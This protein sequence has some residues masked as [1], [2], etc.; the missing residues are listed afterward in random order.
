M[1]SLKNLLVTTDFHPAS[2]AAV[3]MAVHLSRQFESRLTLL[4]VQQ[5]DTDGIIWYHR[6]QLGAMLLSNLANK[7]A[8]Q[9]VLVGAATVELGS[10]VDVILRKATELDV[11]LIVLGIGEA[12]SFDQVSVGPTA[13]SVIEHATQPVLAI[14]PGQSPPSI[15]RILCPVDNSDVSRRGLKNAIRWA[16]ACGSQL[17]VVSVVPDVSWLTAAEET[18]QI[19]D[20]QAAHEQRWCDEFDRFLEEFDFD[21]VSWTREVRKGK[22]YAEIVSAARQHHADVIV[23]GAT[24]FTGMPHLL[25]G[26]TTRR[27]LQHLPCSMLTVKSENVLDADFEDEIRT[28]HTLLDQG[29]VFLEAHNDEAAGDKFDAILR[30]DPFHLPALEG[31]AN[32]CDRLG[33][34]DRA[35]RC[36]RRIELLQRPTEVV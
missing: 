4:H 33:Q 2:D 12:S 20:A 22:P 11:D 36:R 35:A 25:L 14:R 3:E 28:I 1:R 27:V 8:E 13:L 34:S 17:N 21:G 23:M 6:K 10:A 7:L 26:S 5:V 30:L 16:K 32:A 9:H 31:R 18:G 24:G 29:Q 15:Q 19:R